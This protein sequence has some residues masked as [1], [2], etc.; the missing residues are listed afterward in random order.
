VQ[1]VG[2][3]GGAAASFFGGVTGM[4]I[5]VCGGRVVAI[6]VVAGSGQCVWGGEL[7]GFWGRRGAVV[8]WGQAWGGHFHLVFPFTRSH[9]P[10][11]VLSRIPHKFCLTPVSVTY[12]GWS[13]LGVFIQKRAIVCRGLSNLLLAVFWRRNWTW[14]W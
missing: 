10:S 9:L 14:W 6:S 4:G 13:G 2:R 8:T 11:L 7:L 12:V 3:E 5:A 1:G